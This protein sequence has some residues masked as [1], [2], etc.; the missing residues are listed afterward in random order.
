MAGPS[1]SATL[2]NLFAVIAFTLSLISGV[3]CHFVSFTS[4]GSTPITIHFG[5]WY[6][7]GWAFVQ[8]QIQ[9][10]VLLESCYHYPDGTNIDSKW[11]TAAAFSIIALIIGGVTT[12]WAL[13]T[14]CMFPAEGG[15]TAKDVTKNGFVYLFI[16]LCQGLTLLFL[17]SNACTNNSLLA[18][19]E[20]QVPDM[21]LDF[22]E[23]CSLA[24]GAN[25]SIA[26]TVLW[27][28]A[29]VLMVKVEPPQPSPA[30]TETQSVTYTKNTGG[31][32]Q[33]PL[34]GA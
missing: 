17:Q 28:V 21:K 9:G 25:C 29:A 34:M 22:P 20:E 12:F 5:L 6:Y 7:Q 31:D 1:Y 32:L 24:A 10:T 18:G 27:F 4:T 23:T 13:L 11:K 3:L 14:G 15:Y 8:D 30:T 33:E 16:C 2:P 19:L 26:A